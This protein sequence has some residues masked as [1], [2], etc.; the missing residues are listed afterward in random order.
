LSSPLSPLL[1][2]LLLCQDLAL[3]ASSLPIISTTLTRELLTLKKQLIES[4]GMARPRPLKGIWR[5]W[6][7]VEG[8]GPRVQ[9][10]QTEEVERKEREKERDGRRSRREGIRDRDM[11]VYGGSYRRRR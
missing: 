8:Y 10:L 11:K 5:D 2:T 6:R 7:Q 3:P 1:F 4:G 9:V